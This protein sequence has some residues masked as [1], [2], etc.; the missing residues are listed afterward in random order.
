M[1]QCE[2]LAPRTVCAVFLST[3]LDHPKRILVSDGP[4]DEQLRAPLVA[5]LSAPPPTTTPVAD[6]PV[7]EGGEGGAAGS[8]EGGGGGEGGE[9][10]AGGEGTG[11][12]AE[13]A[14]AAADEE[15]EEEDGDGDGDGEGG[16]PPI[17][18]ANTLIAVPRTV[19]EGPKGGPWSN[20]QRSAVRARPHPY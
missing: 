20:T 18:D 7:A 15:E 17:V 10:V 12:Q 2:L 14:A 8:V 16:L 5:K 9:G 4:T 3:F 19:S 11:K 1:A 13:A 6:G